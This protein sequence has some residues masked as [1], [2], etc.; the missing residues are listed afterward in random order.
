MGNLEQLT[1][2]LN[3]QEVRFE[4]LI[5]PQAFTAQEVAHALH[6]T[7]KV[8]AKTIVVEADGKIVM[9]VVPAH[10]KVNLGAVKKVVG[11]EDV[12]L[13]PETKLRELFPESDLGAMPPLGPMYN[14]PVIVSKALAEEPEIIFNAST[15]TDCVKMNYADFARIVNPTVAEVSDIPPEAR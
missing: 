4:T 1:K 10:H 12:H 15:H 3:S 9:T 6:K 14:L 13:V 7:G 2:F 11:A 8:L 5:H